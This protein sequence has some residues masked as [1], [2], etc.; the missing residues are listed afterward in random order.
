M[1]VSNTGQGLSLTRPMVYTS[2]SQPFSYVTSWQLAMAHRNIGPGLSL[3]RPMVY[4]SSSQPFSSVTSWP[5]AILAQAYPLRGQWYTFPVAN[6]SV[7]TS[8]PLAMALRNTGPGLSL[9]RP[10]AHTSSGQPF[11]SV[12]SWP[13]AMTLR[14][15]GPG[16]SLTRPMAHTS[17]G[18]PFSCHRL[19]T[20]N[21]T[22][23]Y[24]PLRGSTSQNIF[25]RPN[26]KKMERTF[27]NQE[28]QQHSV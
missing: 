21:V 27:E 3:M 18:Q 7:V 10:M 20:C 9:T 16:L 26:V 1:A 24:W 12:T 23:Q 13:L 4:T 28:Q 2:S 5:L 11:S 14:N 25:S 8:W 15:T 19:A 22:A 6:R 17:S